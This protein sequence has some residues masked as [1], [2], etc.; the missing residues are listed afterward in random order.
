MEHLLDELPVAGGGGGA[1]LDAHE[2]EQGVE[3]LAA[4]GAAV[5]A[6]AT[7]QTTMRGV[8]T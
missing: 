2:R 8:S 4:R 3:R 1:P 5:L 7:P 6:P